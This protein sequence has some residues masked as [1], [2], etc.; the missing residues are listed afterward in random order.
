MKFK[1][2]S[3]IENITRNKTINYIIETGN[4]IGE[5]VQTLKIHGAN[6]SIW[7]D[8]KDVFRGK[9]S[10]F[11]NNSFYGDFNFDYNQNIRDMFDY[12]KINNP[13]MKVLT[14]YGEIYGGIYNHP[15]VKKVAEATKVQKEVHYRPD[16]SFIV[17]DIKIDGIL[18]DYDTE[19]LLCVKFGFDHVPELARGLFDKLI[20]NPVVFPDP[21]YKVFCLPVIE[22]NDAEG[23]VLKPVNPLFFANGERIILKGKNPEFR[24][25]KKKNKS[26]IIITLS[27][28]GNELRDELLTFITENR[29]RNVLSHGEIEDITPKDFGRLLGLFCQDIFGDFS[30]DFGVDYEELPKKDRN[31]IKK[32]MH[33]EAGNVIRPNFINILDGEF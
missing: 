17:F 13:A 28:K 16:N 4:N 18:V 27:D 2:Y 15:D 24:E 21:L 23:W 19:V 8:G 6:Y 29:L 10:G 22:K 33:R 1:R 5:W 14:V 9:R 32:L 11:I 20:N 7:C 25:E 26:K 3:S 31:I 12:L 30:K